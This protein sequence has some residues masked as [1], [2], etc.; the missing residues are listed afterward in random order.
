MAADLRIALRELCPGR[1][2]LDEPETER[3]GQAQTHLA[4]LRG[5]RE[6]EAQSADWEDLAAQAVEQNPFYEPWMLLPAL[7][8]TGAAPETVLV[9]AGGRLIGLFPLERRPRHHGLPLGELRLWRHALCYLCT[10]L[11]RS[12][13]EREALDAFF[14]WLARDSGTS[15]LRLQY[16]PGEGPFHRALLRHFERHPQLMHFTERY[17][18]ALF[19]PRRSAEGYLRAAVPGRRLKEYRRLARRLADQGRLEYRE[20]GRSEHAPDW[21]GAFLALEERGW[22]GRA[23][24]AL[25]STPASRAWFERIALEAGRRGRLLMHGLYLNGRALA[26]SCKIRAGDGA[27]AFKI[28]YDEDYEQYSPGLLLELEQIVRMHGAARIGWLDSC[29]VPEHFMANRLWLDRR[30]LETVTVAAG[31]AGALLVLLLPFLRW[32][33]RRLARAP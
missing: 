22:K 23:G 31:G 30:A 24:T 1:G 9:H 19:R 4:V 10:P 16:L 21:I 6:L 28:A 7:E 33:R 12:G 26:L 11:V 25:A 27:Y 20:L 3:Q 13:F 14:G 5:A 32:A 29:A 17:T 2:P 18:R 8:A 15:L